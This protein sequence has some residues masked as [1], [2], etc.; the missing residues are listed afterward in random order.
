MRFVITNKDIISHLQLI[1]NPTQ[2]KNAL[3]NLCFDEKTANLDAAITIINQESRRKIVPLVVQILL[4][5]FQQN[6]NK[7]A[8]SAFT[9]L[10]DLSSFEILPLMSSILT[11]FFKLKSSELQI[12]LCKT[13]L[14]KIGPI[15]WLQISDRN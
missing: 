11:P 5:Y 13:T 3:R 2:M 1:A 10:S 9:W 14:S 12:L 4:P 15:D 6:S 8:S 7:Y